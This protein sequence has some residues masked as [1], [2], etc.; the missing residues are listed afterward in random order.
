[1]LLY[2]FFMM[3]LH[4]TLVLAH[5]PH[6]PFSRHVKIFLTWIPQLWRFGYGL[7]ELLHSGPKLVFWGRYVTQI[8]DLLKHD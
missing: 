6:V 3:H 7:A 2:I 4:V 5:F 8:A 1:M